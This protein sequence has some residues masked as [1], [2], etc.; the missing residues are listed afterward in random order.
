MEFTA[1]LIA[2][3]LKGEIIGD[4]DVKVTYVSKIE[5]GK[6]GTLSFLANPKYSK[7][8][9]SSESSIILINKDF[10]VTDEVK[11]T[12]IKVED[13]YKSFA[14]LL[15]L[16]QQSVPKKTGIDATSV[17]DESAMVGEN[18]YFGAYVVI[19]KNAVIGN[20]VKL[21]PHVYIGDNVVVDDNT[22]IYSGVKVYHEC[23]IGCNCIVHGG[24][25]I[26]SDGFGFAPQEGDT[27]KKI[28]QLGNVVIEDDVEVGANTVIDRAT[29]GSTII[30]KGVKLDNLI[31]IAHNAVIGEH[32]VIAA[33]TGVSGST[34]IHEDCMIGG[35]V[36]IVGHINIAPRTKI[37][38]KTGVMSE[39]KE[40]DQILFGHV[41]MPIGLG[42]KVAV[43][44]RKLPDLYDELNRLKK[45]INELKEKN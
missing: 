43:L 21:H 18:C 31:Q 40:P 30:K 29:M 1:K 36:G 42:R 7:Y 33:Q 14:Q 22:E 6:P 19:G 37:S 12:L 9:Y 39:I 25:I 38:P 28:P 26:G 11:A 15:E 44:N 5:E 23:K 4:P 17:V 16:Y 2:E 10:E 35:Q 27:F 20:N 3:H 32:T 41:A 13:A 8:L 45:E 24:A 34:T